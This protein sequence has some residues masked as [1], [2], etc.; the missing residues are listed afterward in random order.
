M[1]SYRLITVEMRQKSIVI[2]MLGSLYGLYVNDCFFMK[3]IL[4]LCHPMDI[5]SILHCR[6]SSCQIRS[7]LPFVQVSPFGRDLRL[8]KLFAYHVKAIK[9]HVVYLCARH[10]FCRAPEILMRSGHGKAVDWWS[11]GALMYDMLTGAVSLYLCRTVEKLSY[12]HLVHSCITVTGADWAQFHALMYD[13]F[14]NDIG[15]HIQALTTFV[16]APVYV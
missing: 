15:A 3:S 13:M 16:A 14:L 4:F 11:L 10:L 6:L 5:L 7:C 8:I 1:L 12:R 9:R 2:Q